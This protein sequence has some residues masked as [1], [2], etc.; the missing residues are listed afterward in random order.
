[1]RKK[2]WKEG[3]GGGGGVIMYHSLEGQDRLLTKEHVFT[4]DFTDY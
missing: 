1:M 2:R 3:G 4:P